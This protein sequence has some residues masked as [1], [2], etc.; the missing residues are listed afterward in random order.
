VRITTR[1]DSG[2]AA[3]EAVGAECLIGTP[4]RLASLRG[5]LEGVT[6]A[7]WMLVIPR[8]A[9]SEASMDSEIH[10]HHNTIGVR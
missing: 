5:A 10:S 1:T 3:I 9:G 7:C 8:R 4:D 6:V 2:R